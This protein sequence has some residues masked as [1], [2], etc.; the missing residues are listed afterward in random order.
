M[1]FLEKL[2]E[3]LGDHALA[4]DQAPLTVEALADL[5][6]AHL[7]AKEGTGHVG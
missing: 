4:I 2:Q 6:M 7:P 5:L 1:Q 3:R